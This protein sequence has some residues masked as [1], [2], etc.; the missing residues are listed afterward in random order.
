MPVLQDSATSNPSLMTSAGPNRLLD[1]IPRL[2]W[3]FFA[4]TV[5]FML[6]SFNGQWRVARDSAAYRGLGHQLATTGKYVFRDKQDVATYSDQ[7]DT[8]YPGMPLMLAGVEKVF[9]RHDAPAVLSVTLLGALAVVLSYFLVRPGLPAWLTVAV[10]FGTGINGRFLTYSQ[11]ILADVPFLAGV[12]L[13]LLA[14]DRLQRAR[15]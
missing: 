1:L 10:V 8:R 2:R 6:L 3:A 7:Q 4:L 15:N 11:E 12:V 13:S 5:G 14:F 9:G